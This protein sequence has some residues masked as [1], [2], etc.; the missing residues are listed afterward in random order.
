[1]PSTV[2]GPGEI[3]VPRTDRQTDVPCYGSLWS[4][5]RHQ[6]KNSKGGSFRAETRKGVRQV[7]VDEGYFK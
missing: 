7:T 5:Q 4:N 6:K 2:L 1:M 3:A